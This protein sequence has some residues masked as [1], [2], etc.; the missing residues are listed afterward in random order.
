MFSFIRN[1]FKYEVSKK[2]NLNDFEL[3]YEKLERIK[4][5]KR[6]S[7]IFYFLVLPVISYFIISHLI[8][9]DKRDMWR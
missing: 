9:N 8:E 6:Y 4:S 3:N 7:K 5:F 2:P 1:L